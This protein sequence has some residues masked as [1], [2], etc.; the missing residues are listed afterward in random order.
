MAVALMLSAAT[1]FASNQ[2]TKPSNAKTQSASEQYTC[3]MHKDVVTDKPGKCPKCGMKLQKKAMATYSC[4][5]HKDV[6]SNKPGK[7]SK[8]GMKLEKKAAAMY[9]CP[10]DKDVTSNKPGKCPKCGMDLEQAKM[11]HSHKM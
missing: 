11:D 10:M 7:C 5:M 3:P 2:Q 6:V 4:P 9:S 8:C 1:L